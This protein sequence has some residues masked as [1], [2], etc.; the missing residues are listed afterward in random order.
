MLRC[1]SVH[2]ENAPLRVREKFAFPPQVRRELYARLEELGGGLLLVTCNRT[3]LYCFCSEEAAR[4]LL[5]GAAGAEAPLFCAEGGAARERLFLLAAGLCSML[6]GEDEILHQ[7]KNAYA[8]AQAAGATKGADSLFQAALACGRRV[9]AETKLSEYA[10]SVAT[11]A[12]N[13]V[14]R[15]T[16]GHGRVLLVGGSGMVGGAALK[17]LLSAGHT[18]A[19]TE[20]THAFGASAAGAE[21]I[22]YA[23]RYAALDRADAVVSC[24]ASPH[25]VFEAEKVR[26]AIRTA[27]ERLFLDL[28]VPP[29]IDPAVGQIAGC[30]L[31]NIDDFRAEAEENNAR[32]RAAA[33]RA[34]GVVAACLDEYAAG[35]AARL[36]AALV[37]KDG[38]LCALKKR[39]PA[40]FAAEMRARFGEGR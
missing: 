3:E 22:A 28:A 8:E 9:R 33:E 18:V 30:R 40:A 31:K 13:E 20:R 27:R 12:A 6:V 38:A 2:F 19:A 25:V 32:K 39:D 11:L 35:E 23:E 29:D 16:R 17:N 10:C 21:T 4:A 37:R 24:T 15:F 1:L 34:R 5:F 36:H 14:T 26:R 7:L